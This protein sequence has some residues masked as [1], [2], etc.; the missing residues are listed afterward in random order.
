MVHLVYLM[1]LYWCHSQKRKTLTVN[2]SFQCTN[3]KSHLRAIEWFT[4]F[5]VGY[6]FKSS[7]HLKLQFHFKSQLHF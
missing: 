2:K 7:G 4:F 5:V 3:E 1:H 6:S